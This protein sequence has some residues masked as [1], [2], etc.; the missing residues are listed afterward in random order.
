M[1]CAIC[2]EE[3]TL[4]CKRADHAQASILRAKLRG[5]PWSMLVVHTES[6][7]KRAFDPAI[8]L[9][10]GDRHYLDGRPIHCGD[11]L[12]LQHIAVR[13]DDFGEFTTY[14]DKATLVRYEVEHTY[15]KNR[16][17][18]SGRIAVMY[19]SVAGRSFRTVIDGGCYFRWPERSGSW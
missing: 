15:N 14:L 2:W 7:G 19:T 5:R 18:M 11:A 4:A 10:Y 9:V 1:S 12:E 16:T 13:S 8:E 6:G 3:D 17:P